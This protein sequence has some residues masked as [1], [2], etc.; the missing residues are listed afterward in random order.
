MSTI[1]EGGPPVKKTNIRRL[2]VI[3]QFQTN[4]ISLYNGKVLKLR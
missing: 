1:I 3:Y 2:N 4:L